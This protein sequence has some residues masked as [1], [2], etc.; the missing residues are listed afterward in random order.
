KIGTSA[1]NQDTDLLAVRGKDRTTGI[2]GK[3]VQIVLEGNV[4]FVDGENL[5][6]LHHFL[7]DPHG[8]ADHNQGISGPKLRLQIKLNGLP[9]YNWSVEF[10][11]GEV[12]APEGPVKIKIN[13]F[14]AR[15]DLVLLEDMR[16]L[17]GDGTSLI[18]ENNFIDT[19]TE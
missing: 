15:I 7:G 18:V 8:I 13:D 11:D 5:S 4:L 6:V 17:H 16:S 1:A 19:T 10:Y 14:L 3:A 2:N 12:H 9:S